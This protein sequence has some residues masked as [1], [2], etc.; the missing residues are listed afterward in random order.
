LM[1]SHA[2][3]LEKDKI[4]NQQNLF[5]ETNENQLLINLPDT[6]EWSAQEKLNN[7]FSSL[8]L[9]LS[10]HPLNSY[11]EI[12][13]KIQAKNSLEISEEP[14]IYF[15]KNIQLC[16]IVSKIKRRISSRG[17]WASFHLNDLGGDTEIV[18]YSDSL[19]KYE[20]YLYE[21]NL[22]LIDVEIKNESNQGSR[23]IARRIRPLNQFISDNKFD[24]LLYSKNNNFLDKLLPLLN[25]LELGHSNVSLISSTEKEKVEIKIKK[26]VKLS[27]KLINDLSLING[28]DNINF[29]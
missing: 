10:S 7:E 14:H 8:G 27:S 22:I 26:N 23:I 28:I 11:L 6:Q 20:A 24:V 18:I 5:N 29:I 13:K 9:Y 4:T 12:L 3:T 15:G 16:G 21:R 25:N 1:I 19:T 2:Q 17:R